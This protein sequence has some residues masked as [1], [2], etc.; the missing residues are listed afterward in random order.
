MRDERAAGAEI[1]VD[2][3]VD[4]LDHTVARA[5][6]GHEDRARLQRRIRVR[7]GH[8]ALGEL[9]E[10][11]VVRGVADG[12]D[13]VPR[14]A[15]RE[16]RAR[17]AGGLVDAG[18]EDHHRL[19]VE[20]D[21]QLQAE[22]I[23]GV[24]DGVLVGVLRRDDDAPDSSGLT[25]R[26]CR[27]RTNSCGT[28][29]H[30]AVVSLRDGQCRTAPFS[31]TTASKRSNRGNAGARSSRRRPVTRIDSTAGGPQALQGFDADGATRPST[32]RV[33]S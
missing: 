32:A 6:A 27:A 2:E 19:A 16:Q 8:G 18:G 17:E 11:V 13:F 33:P 26:S 28:G 10:R 25:R 21:L 14:Q 23:E 7:D 1:V 22:V 12:D 9:E 30:S 24:D 20:D 3:L 31:A 5:A 29:L 4:E 15:H